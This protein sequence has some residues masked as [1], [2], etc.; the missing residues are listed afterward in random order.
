MIAQVSSTAYENGEHVTS[1]CVSAGTS[2][3]RNDNVAMLLYASSKLK[4]S[5]D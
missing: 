1:D 2:A 3:T 4:L 5:F